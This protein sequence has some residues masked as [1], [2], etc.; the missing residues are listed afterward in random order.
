LEHP[1]ILWFCCFF[2]KI[3]KNS[4]CFSILHRKLMTYYCSWSF[5]FHAK[6][7]DVDVI[8]LFLKVLVFPIISYYIFC[9]H[10][11]LLLKMKFYNIMLI[12]MFLL[13]KKVLMLLE[14]LFMR[15]SLL[16]FLKMILVLMVVLLL[17]VCSL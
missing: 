11:K 8:L 6:V 10:R 9:F 1:F 12:I 17:W 2:K 3:Q 13:V 15:V 5:I 7:F 14:V 4:N 16:M